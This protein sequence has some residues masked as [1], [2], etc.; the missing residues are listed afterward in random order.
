[1]SDLT[2]AHHHDAELGQWTRHIRAGRTEHVTRLS[3]YH[4]L[5]PSPGRHVTPANFTIPL[6]IQFSRL[7]VESPGRTPIDTTAF[8]A[9]LT[10]AVG[11]VEAD[12]FI[13]M[14]ADL[15]PIAAYRL[16]RGAIAPLAGTT[17]SVDE[18]FG[19]R[20]RR[21]VE[22]L[23]NTENWRTRLDVLEE[24]LIE[25]I[26]AGSQPSPEVI[27]A[28]EVTARRH[29]AIRVEELAFDLGW[30]VRHLRNRLGE[31]LGVSPKV[32]AR[33]AR[34]DHAT[35]LLERQAY[36][37]LGRIAL[38]AGFYDQA[39]LTNEWKRMAGRTPLQHL[40]VRGRR[41][42]ADSSK[43]AVELPA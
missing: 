1:M 43:T 2:T 22:R 30:S 12:R 39:H 11:A 29:G 17:A 37:D 32:L 24:F 3:G 15:T 19:P 16:T 21:L 40:H 4:Q 23:G 18:V 8:V 35:R 7:R 36:A 41:D 9:G 14:Q 33:L 13:G 10:D 6:V 5:T 26:E 34:F 42:R 28:W 27:G 31:E 25:E 38:A 20:G